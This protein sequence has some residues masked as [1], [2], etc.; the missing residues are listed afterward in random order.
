VA[1][2]L[3][4][5]GRWHATLEVARP[6]EIRRISLHIFDRTFAV[7]YLLEAV[8]IVIGL[9]GVAASFASLAATRRKEFGM[10]RHLGVSRAQIGAML[11]LEGGWWPA[12]AC[13][14]AC[15]PGP[16]SA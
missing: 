11:A 1:N 2:R 14:A 12:S 13:S 7:T 4:G 6:G 10:L 16:V 5:A 15:W 8:A 3:H 9:A